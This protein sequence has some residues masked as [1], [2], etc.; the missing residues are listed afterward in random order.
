[1]VLDAHS[2]VNAATA[3]AAATAAA[4]TATARIKVLQV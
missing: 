4:D 1:M 2:E 3:F